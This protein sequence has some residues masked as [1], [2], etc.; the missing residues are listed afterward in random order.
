M[1]NFDLTFFK[2]Y[3]YAKEWPVIDLGASHESCAHP[4]LKSPIMYHKM[5]FQ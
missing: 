2:V 4:N 1:S 5:T 3:I